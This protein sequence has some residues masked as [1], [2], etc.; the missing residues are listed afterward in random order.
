MF[1]SLTFSK[2]LDKLKAIKIEYTKNIIYILINKIKAMQNPSI[3]VKLCYLF[4]T[5]RKV[6]WLWILKIKLNTV[7]YNFSNAH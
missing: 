4:N 7:W 5:C 6:K 3:F 1:F 2:I